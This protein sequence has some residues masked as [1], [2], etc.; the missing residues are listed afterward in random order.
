[1]TPSDHRAAFLC[2]ESRGAAC[3][4]RV[5][6]E[7][8]ALPGPRTAVRVLECSE[9]LGA[10]LRAGEEARRLGLSVNAGHG[11]TYTNVRGLVAALEVG[12]LHIGHSIVARAVLVGMERAAREMCRLIGCYSAKR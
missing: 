8:A 3:H 9:R 2:S 6:L 12:E 1:M 10:L 4:V 5:C 11:L 7:G